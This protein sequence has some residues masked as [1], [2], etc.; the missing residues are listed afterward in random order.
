M[1]RLYTFLNN[2]YVT[3]QFVCHGEC[4]IESVFDNLLC[5]GD[6]SARTS[7]VRMAVKFTLI[8]TEFIL[9]R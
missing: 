9:T 2:L 8:Q 3:L 7:E 1:N 5:T 6:G 4:G